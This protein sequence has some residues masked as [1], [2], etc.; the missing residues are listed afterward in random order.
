MQLNNKIIIRFLSGLTFLIFF[1]PFFQM[2]SDEAIK[3]SPLKEF[4]IKNGT[5]KKEADSLLTIF[6]KK[7]IEQGRKEYTFNA[8]QI[9]KKAFIDN[10]A[11]DIFDYLDE[12]D[13]YGSLCY[14]LF[15]IFSSIGLFFSLKS[16]FN[17][18]RIFNYVNIT[19]IILSIF[20]FYLKEG[21]LEDINQIK[22]G[23]Y[24]FFLNSI[25]II[26]FCNKELKSIQ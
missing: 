2:C 11:L 21:L 10:L 19:L 23:Y 26:Y 25:V 16:K 18:T 6:Y 9:T 22:I 12:I 20:F 5:P 14:P 1:C 13:I 24:L 4:S 8:Y 7:K 17:R 15:I 3:T